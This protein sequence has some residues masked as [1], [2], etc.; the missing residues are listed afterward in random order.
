[1][2]EAIDIYL[3]GSIHFTPVLLDAIDVRVITI[4]S[5]TRTLFKLSRVVIIYVGNP[6][7]IGLFI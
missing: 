3:H 5:S 2:H 4:V 7:R 6:G 1:M